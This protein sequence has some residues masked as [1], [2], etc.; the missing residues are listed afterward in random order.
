MKFKMLQHI[1]VALVVFGALT[2]CSN[3]PTKSP[4][5]VENVRKSLDEGGLK[6]VSVSQDREKG[7][8]TLA[9]T[10][11]SEAEKLQAESVAKSFAGSQVVADQIAV[12]PPGEEKIAKA[13]DSD[14]DDGIE[15][16]FHAVLVSHRLEH[17]M[18][19]GVK[20]GVI[21]LSGTV[22]S[23]SKRSLVE[24]M[25]TGVPN[26]KQVVNELQVKGQK[27]TSSY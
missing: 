12:R 17:D 9:G 19:Y 13:V 22:N 24:S 15:S 5:V 26:V 1:S 8:V 4:D 25:A 10:T 11:G 21:T 2:G 14:L 27:A 6:D 3:T 7:I 20:N 16:N 18:T 23:Q